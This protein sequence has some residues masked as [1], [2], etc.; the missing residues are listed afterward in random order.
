VITSARIFNPDKEQLDSIYESQPKFSDKISNPRLKKIASFFDQ[1]PL[2][3]TGFIPSGMIT[4]PIG[5][6]VPEI[7][8][9]LSTFSKHGDEISERTPYKI[10][11]K[12]NLNGLNNYV[13]D[14]KSSSKSAIDK[15]KDLYK[16]NFFVDLDIPKNSIAQSLDWGRG[17]ESGLV[18]LTKAMETVPRGLLDHPFLKKISLGSDDVG[19]TAAANYDSS[20]RTINIGND[21]LSMLGYGKIDDSVISKAVNHEAIHGAHRNLDAQNKSDLVEEFLRRQGWT[22]P[23][24]MNKT[25]ELSKDFNLWQRN[26][27]RAERLKKGPDADVEALV[28]HPYLADTMDGLFNIGYGTKY[29]WPTFPDNINMSSNYGN[30]HPLEDIAE[31][32]AMELLDDSLLNKNHFSNGF[33]DRRNFNEIFKDRFYETYEKDMGLKLSSKTAKDIYKKDLA[34]RFAIRK[35]L[36]QMGVYTKPL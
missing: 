22:F 16:K 7:K 8:D 32:G 21:L 28:N 1:S 6:V 35:L 19:S 26:L 29:G 24:I 9:V 5:K 15:V 14:M 33:L 3:L 17:G 34:R 31:T 11:G 10:D 18:Q 20:T 27:D 12:L 13:Q 25:G 30:Y 4:R 2:D 23:H 36:T